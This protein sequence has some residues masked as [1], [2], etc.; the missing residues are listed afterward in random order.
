ML[1]SD[2]TGADMML[3]QVGPDNVRTFIASAGLT[4]R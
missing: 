1:H 4:R 2:N 3:K